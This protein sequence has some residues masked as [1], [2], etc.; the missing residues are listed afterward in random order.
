VRERALVPTL[1]FVGLVVA[2]V[3]SLGAPL[4]PTVARDTGVSG[5]AAQWTLTG[6]LLVGAVATPV[7]GRLGDGPH[8][9]RVVLTALAIVLA[10]SALTV[11]P[12]GFG[13]LLVGRCLQGVG[14]G[15]T[16]LVIAIAR[17]AFTGAR[18]GSVIGLLAVTSIAGIGIGYPIAGA[19]TLYI[20]LT[21]AYAAGL[22]VVA[23]AFVLAFVVIPHS[24]QSGRG[25]LDILG[26]VLLG[27]SLTVVLLVIGGLGPAWW[28]PIAVAVGAAWVWYELRAPRPLVQL[29]L[30]RIPA[31]LVADATVL[32]GG[33]GMYLLM[34]LTTRYVQSGL[35]DSVLV[36]G[37]VLVPF[38]L[39]S[40]V[41]SRVVPRLR[42]APGVVLA[43]ACLVVLLASLAFA[44]AR[45]QLWE[46]FAVM[47]VAGFG[48][49]GMFAA[50]PA[51]IVRAV[52]PGET[53]SAVGFNQV[54]RTI[55]FSAG[56]ALAGLVLAAA[57]APGAVNP[58]ERGYTTAA[59]IG[60]GFLALTAIVLIVI[61]RAR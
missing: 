5:A 11:L 39:F 23:A 47:A 36:A 10:G 61:R 55:G 18:A 16:S 6:T 60:A 31:V 48:V 32:L 12:L 13:G 57:T 30:V 46:S 27:A 1:V 50:A 24:G 49:G 20:G 22:V 9:R 51:F 8:R 43:A 29:R 17:D 41:A 7:L 40:F 44:L 21:S 4:I 59:L 2:A 26:T 28:L 14:L 42:A 37:L 19:L 15:L 56:S 25:R 58:A 35:G 52:P 3:G 33:V 53:G 54:L 34:T 45:A 38:S